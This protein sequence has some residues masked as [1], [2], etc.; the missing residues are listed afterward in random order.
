[1]DLSRFYELKPKIKTGDLLAVHTH[2]II[3]TLIRVKTHSEFSHIGILLTLEEIPGEVFLVH[4]SKHAGGVCIVLASR[5]LHKLDGYAA[6]VEIDH[7][8][9]RFVNPNYQS[10][11]ICEAMNQ[12]GLDFDMNTLLREAFGLGFLARA[13]RLFF[14]KLHE[15][16]VCSHITAHVW[17]KA[18]LADYPRMNPQ[19]LLEQQICETLKYLTPDEGN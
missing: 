3:P 7:D 5:F 17:H 18:G 6:I 16:W 1:M 19:E 12:L 9:A 15:A 11:I 14:P 4:S 8:I 2:G 10:Q 13:V